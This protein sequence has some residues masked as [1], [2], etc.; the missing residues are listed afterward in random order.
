MDER[1]NLMK[2]N[3]RVYQI[4][5][6]VLTCIVFRSLMVNFKKHFLSKV[7]LQIIRI[8]TIVTEH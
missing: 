1:S 6:D 3:V 8:S 5:L 7:I 4:P 2:V